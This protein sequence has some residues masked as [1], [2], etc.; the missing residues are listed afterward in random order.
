MKLPADYYHCFLGNGL[1]AVLIGYTGSMVS[2]KVSV[3]RC[4]WYKSDRYYPEDKLVMVAG[5]WPLDQPLKHAEGSGWY[6]I[7]PLGRTWY[8]V[9]LPEQGDRPLEVSASRQRFVPQEGTL[10]SAV[11]YGSLHVQVTTFLHAQRSLLIERYQ[12]DREVAFE[13]WMGPGVWLEDVWD[14]DPFH[15]VALTAGKAEIHYDLGETRGEIAMRLE[16][17]PDRFGH[18]GN[19]YCLRAEGR[20]FVKYFSITDERQQPTSAAL[21]SAALKTGYDQLWAEHVAFWRSYFSR[22]TISIPS[23]RFQSF[24]ESSLYHFKG[25]QNPVSG[26]LPVNNLRRTWSSHVFWDSYFIQRALLEANHVPEALEAIRFFQRTE[27]AARRHAREEFGCDGL[28]WDWEITHDGRKAYGALLHMKDQV[29]NN[30]SYAN[31]IWQYYEFTRDLSILREFYPIL[32]GIARY[33][34]CDVVEKTEQGY[35]T[36]PV[37]GVHESPIR[38]RNDGITLAGTIV[39]LQHTVQAARLLGIESDFVEDCAQ[40]IKGLRQPLQDLYNGRYFTA[41]ADSTALNMS[42][43]GPL[44]P[45]RVLSFTDPQALSTVE[46]YR[47]YYHGRMVGHGGNENGF[48]WSAGVLATVC[49]HQRQGDQAWEV[50]EGTEPAICSFGGMTEVMEAGQWNM[51]YFGTAQGAVCTALHNLLLQSEADE[52]RVFPALPSSWSE[53]VF[54]RLLANGCEVSASV[55]RGSGR[56]DGHLVNVTAGPLALRLRAGQQDETVKLASG[57]TYHFKGEL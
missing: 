25:M 19:E 49:A 6:E 18:S 20:E 51:Q 22:S 31:E 9:F 40:A 57:E 3:D 44:Y 7:A 52:I 13:A 45:M 27:P 30:A 56:I 35:A 33:F 46:A 24:Y 55:G 21:L 16:P 39:L 5:R 43:L 2:D 15:S 37:V 42:S 14:T 11:S 12:F 1:D 48:P 47:E 53:A 50:I 34:L 41:S 17:A 54:E 26:G 29:H 10:Y 4:A 8:Q 28:K 23:A 36:R 38:V 32:E